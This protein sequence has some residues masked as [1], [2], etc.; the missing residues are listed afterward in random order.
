M[1]RFR[2]PLSLEI[3][4]TTGKQTESLSQRE[5]C[6]RIIPEKQ[7]RDK[8]RGAARDM[9]RSAVPDGSCELE[10]ADAPADSD[11]RHENSRCGALS[12]EDPK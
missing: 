8:Q 7:S 11:G 5:L 12:W 9:G 3:D 10:A 2:G 6:R 4:E 1:T